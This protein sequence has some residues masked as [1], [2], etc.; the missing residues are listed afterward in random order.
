MQN[1]EIRL[2]EEKL[3][4]EKKKKLEEEKLALLEQEKLALQEELE[5]QRIEFEKEK[6]KAAA[7]LA[8]AKKTPEQKKKEERERK[9][10]LKAKQKYEALYL[11]V[12]NDKWGMQ[13]IS[14][15]MNG[16]SY[17]RF[18]SQKGEMFY[19]GGK[20]QD[21]GGMARIVGEIKQISA[22]K[23]T[24]TQIFFPTPSNKLVYGAIG[25]RPSAKVHKTYT[26]I[27]EN[28]LK[29]KSEIQMIDLDAILNGYKGDQVG[30]TYK[31]EFGTRVR[32]N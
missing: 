6:K 21:G 20:I 3:A 10:R 22:D 27:N 13:G 26:I 2:K 17:H 14:C 18:L 5:R 19:A 15:N 31:T 23:F 29:F 12:I 8:E 30:Y 7:E 16:G 24:A 1:K 28:L 11:S 9:K 32:C 25:N 4:A